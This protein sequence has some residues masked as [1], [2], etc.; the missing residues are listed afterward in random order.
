MREITFRPLRRIKK[1]GKIVVASYMQWN[2]VMTSDYNEFKLTVN[3]EYKTFPKDEFVYNHLGELLFFMDYNPADV[4]V[5]DSKA[6]RIL[7]EDWLDKLHHKKQPFGIRW[8]NDGT[9][10]SHVNYSMPCTD[11]IG[12]PTFTHFTMEYVSEYYC[13]SRGGY[14][15]KIHD[16]NPLTVG[17]V[18]KWFGWFLYQLQNS[19]LQIGK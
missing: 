14:P 10:T 8:E 6:E 13:N 3:D 19:H 15:E 5:Y 12:T 9:Y 1:T 4:P 16:F 2:R 17:I 7:D 18:V 11:C